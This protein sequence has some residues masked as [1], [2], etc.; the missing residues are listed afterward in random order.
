MQSLQAMISS[1]TD[2][3]NSSQVSQLRNVLARRRP[4]GIVTTMRNCQTCP[5][6]QM[7]WSR[8]LQNTTMVI[9]HTIGAKQPVTKATSRTMR[10]R[11]E[12]A[13]CA[14]RSHSDV[15]A[16]GGPQSQLTRCLAA[17]FIH[18]PNKQL[19]C[20]QSTITPNTQTH[21]SVAPPVLAQSRQ[22]CHQNNRRHRKSN[23]GCD[24]LAQRA[25]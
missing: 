14:V 23:V 6:S 9:Q 17:K 10:W 13:L 20:G 11:C 21:P 24:E 7:L 15:Y 5:Q 25:K 2:M 1:P 8:L 18:S 3:R 19:S 16:A 22:G 4:S 12:Q